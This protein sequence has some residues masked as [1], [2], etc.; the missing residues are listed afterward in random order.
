MYD[1]YSTSVF[2]YRLICSL[3][4]RT[5]IDDY[6]MEHMNALNKKNACISSHEQQFW[7]SLNVFDSSGVSH[8]THFIKRIIIIYEPKSFFFC[9]WI[10]IN[11]TRLM[12]GVSTWGIH[13]GSGGLSVYVYDCLIWFSWKKDAGFE[14]R[15]SLRQALLSLRKWN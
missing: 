8:F 14:M 12:C 15:R 5:C 4:T 9:I 2:M 13:F 1:V 10:K 7:H 6:G 3:W 11:E